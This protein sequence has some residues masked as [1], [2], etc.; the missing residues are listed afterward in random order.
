MPEILLML[1]IVV[2]AMAAQFGFLAIMFRWLWSI[3]KMQMKI[4][5]MPG[6]IRVLKTELEF[7]KDELAANK[8]EWEKRNLLEKLKE[9]E[10]NQS[11]FDGQLVR[12]WDR[13][14]RIE[15]HIGLEL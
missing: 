13:L 7:L 8:R 5:S 9:F 14:K 3:H 10:F 11:K 15:R 12:Q 1:K 4:G 6:E 2:A